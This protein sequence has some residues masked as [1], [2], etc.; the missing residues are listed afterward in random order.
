MHVC[1]LATFVTIRL[2]KLLGENGKV[3]NWPENIC[4]HPANLTELELRTSAT[5]QEAAA[6]SPIKRESVAPVPARIVV[7]LH[8][9]LG[10][11]QKLQDK[12]L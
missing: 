5:Q 8:Q 9:P 12:V 2:V 1:Q 7:A 6:V 10:I 11:A 3:E 4:K